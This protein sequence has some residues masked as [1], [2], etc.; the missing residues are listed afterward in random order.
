MEQILK[1][2]PGSD[3]HQLKIYEELG[4]LYRFW[5]ERINVISRKDIDHLYERHIL[6]SLSIAKIIR[7]KAGTRIMDGG[8]GGGFPGLPLAVM[9][10]D[11]VFDLVDSTRKKLTVVDEIISRTGISN[12]RTIHSRLEEMDGTYDFIISRAVARL[13]DFYGL[14]RGRIKKDGF[15]ELPNG[16]LYL[17]GGDVE[18]EIRA[19]GLDHHIYNLNEIFDEPFF[20]TKKL[21]HLSYFQGSDKK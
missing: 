11:C 19:T 21:I 14:T 7:F 1:Y 12:V 17:K 9:F 4:P 13:D 16:L 8:T 5:N 3:P 10:P 15:N 18:A 20:E 2:F 6:H